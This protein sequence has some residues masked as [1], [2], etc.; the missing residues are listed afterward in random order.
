VALIRVL[1]ATDPWQATI[2]FRNTGPTK[3]KLANVVPLGGL[4]DRVHITAVGPPSLSRSALFRPGLGAI[5]VI[6]PDNAWEMGFC[7]LP[8]GADVSIAAVARRTGS[9][10]GEERRFSTILEPGGGSVTYRMVLEPH[11]GDWREGLR[12]VFRDRWIYDLRGFNDELFRREDLS[13]IRKSYLLTLFFAWDREYVDSGEGGERFEELLRKHRQSF[14]AY[15]AFMLWPTWPRLG[16]DERNQWDLYRDLPGGL[17]RLRHQAER[18]HRQGTKFFIAYNP[19]DESSRPED[20]LRGMESI[21][22]ATDADGVVLDTRGGSSGELQATADRVKKG[23]IMYSEGMAVP[24]DMPWIVAGRVHD[25][26]VLPPP[27]NLNKLIKPEFAIFRV[28]QVADGLLHREIALSLFN[29]YGVELNVMRA[30]RPASMEEEYRYLG[31]AVRI[32]REN[33][34]CFL[35]RSWMPLYPSLAESVWVNRWPAGDK[36]VYTVYGATPRGHDGPLFSVGRRSGVHYVSLWRH[37]E[38]TRDS[39]AERTLLGSR[40]DPFPTSWLRTRREGNV[41]VIAE[42]PTH[43]SVEVRGESLF[44]ESPS[45]GELRIW[46]GDPSYATEPLRRPAGRAVCSLY[47]EF[48]EMEGKVVVQLVEGG[49]LLDER[50]VEVRPATPGLLPPSGPTPRAATAPPGMV[51]IPSG[52]F[53]YSATLADDANPVIPYPDLSRPRQSSMPR[54]FI[55][56]FPVTNR[57]FAAFLAAARYR[58]VDTAGFLRHWRGGKPQAGELD[59]P[60]VWVSLEDARAYA[61]WAAKRL[62]SAQEW[63][64]AAQGGDGRA[65]PW[66]NEFDSARCNTGRGRPTPVNAYPSGGSPFGMLDCVG[67]VWQMTDDVY[68]NGSYRYL[69]MK[70]GSWYDPR[71]SIWYVKGGPARVDRQQMLLL[72]SGALDRNGT[73]GFRCV[74]DAR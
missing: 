42:L 63:Q 39:L 74:K 28:L 31:R 57:E 29:G 60:V 17:P 3:V 8:A 66:G 36:V 22:R 23:I 71:A 14:G 51:E 48:G 11:A 26:L 18:A 62:P 12:L 64:Y 5:G 54:Y 40:V 38:L 2:A 21:L 9:Q 61:R 7:D 58:P 53:L 25:A 50:V 10:R 56:R 6:L 20:H 15:D 1:A 41:D 4:P 34:D 33:S 45:R 43:L 46:R 30:G 72:G 52:T 67:N 73:V 37:E 16:I 55:D 44:V 68:V 24:A 47:R 69:M 27:L 65:Y 49:M 59:H 13:W 70:G 32:L 35:S 19:W